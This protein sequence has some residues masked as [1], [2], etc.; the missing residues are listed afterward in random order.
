MT[1]TELDIFLA[2]G[3]YAAYVWPAFAVTAI[4]MIGLL[5]VSAR[6]LRADERTLE[7][8]QV[9]R[10]KPRESSAPATPSTPTTPET[11]HGA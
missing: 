8:L 9:D 7:L 3:G 2:M 1:M 11:A 4:V 10:R 6:R 5:I